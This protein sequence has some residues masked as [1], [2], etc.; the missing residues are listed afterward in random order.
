MICQ[1]TD[2]Y[3][4]GSEHWLKWINRDTG[5]MFFFFFFFPFHVKYRLTDITS[6][7]SK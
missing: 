3:S 4:H 7:P 1:L 5:K 6:R 2:L